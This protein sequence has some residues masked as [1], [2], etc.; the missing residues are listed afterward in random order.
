VRPQFVQNTDLFLE[1]VSVLSLGAV[2]RSDLTSDNSS[3]T[4]AIVIPLST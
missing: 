1:C 4:I 3:L 2:D